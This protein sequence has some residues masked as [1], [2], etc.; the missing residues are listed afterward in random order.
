MASKK[1]YTIREV[2]KGREY[3]HEGTLPELIQHYSYRLECNDVN[4]TTIK[5]VRTLLK[6]LNEG[7]DYWS[8]NASYELL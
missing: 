8:N 6:H 7:R 1:Q 3:I 2:Y 4:P 5:S